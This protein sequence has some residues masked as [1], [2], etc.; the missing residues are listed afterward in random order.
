MGKARM[1]FRI[2]IKVAKIGFKVVKK[3]WKG[4]RAFLGFS[5]KNKGKI[6]LGLSSLGTLG[7]TTLGYFTN[8]GY[9]S[10]DLAASSTPALL[11][12]I[13]TILSFIFYTIF[14]PSYSFLKKKKISRKWIL[15]FSA[16][17]FSSLF[18][19]TFLYIDHKKRYPNEPNKSKILKK[20]KRKFR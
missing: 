4:I 1:L 10:L 11:S 18:S 5:Y 14:L 8:V 6:A 17:A 7:I 19:F 9:R 16:L 15:L 3:S 2:G 20:I 12:A 13:G